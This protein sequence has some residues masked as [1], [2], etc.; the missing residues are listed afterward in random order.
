MAGGVTF[1]MFFDVE[2]LAAD[3]LGCALEADLVVALDFPEVSATGEVS[4]LIAS[5][6]TE[7]ISSVSPLK[8]YNSL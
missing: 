8:K 1:D 4:F 6:L 3:S 7:G 2:A 5:I